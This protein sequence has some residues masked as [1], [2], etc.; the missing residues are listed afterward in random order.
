MCLKINPNPLVM[1]SSFCFLSDSLFFVIST[2]HLC[3]TLLTFTTDDQQIE[4]IFSQSK[5]I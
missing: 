5:S 3:F 2:R 1:V 4:K